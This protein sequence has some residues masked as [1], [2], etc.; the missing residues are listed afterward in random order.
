MK[1]IWLLLCG[2]ILCGLTIAQTNQYSYDWQ[3]HEKL[4]DEQFAKKCKAEV[5]ASERKVIEALLP[6][7]KV[8]AY[9]KQFEAGLSSNT[10]LILIEGGEQHWLELAY[11][12]GYQT[13][14]VFHRGYFDGLL[15][16]AERPEVTK[17]VK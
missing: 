2:A 6:K 10:G 15:Q 5:L 11:A 13:K 4:I 7:E 1:V 16:S 9:M 14:M 8:D 12:K 3:L 17:P